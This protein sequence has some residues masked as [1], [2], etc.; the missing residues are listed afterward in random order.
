MRRRGFVFLGFDQGPVGDLIFYGLLAGFKLVDAL[1]QA[2]NNLIQFLK[3]FI[4]VRDL[5]FK[6]G[7]TLL[8]K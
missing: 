2:N 7:E 8:H 6:F 5:A 4:L 1:V 3:E